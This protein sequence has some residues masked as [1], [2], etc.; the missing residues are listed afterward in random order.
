MELAWCFIPPFIL[1]YPFILPLSPLNLHTPPHYHPSVSVPVS[2]SPTIPSF[3]PPSIRSFI[4]TPIPSSI[5]LFLLHHIPH[6]SLPPLFFSLSLTLSSP[7]SLLFPLLSLTL[8][9][10]FSYQGFQ[11]RID[12]F[13]C[14]LTGGRIG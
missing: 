4:L 2:I 10:S 6:L 7:L 3:V 11:Q 1:N 5:P 14:K 13:F 8:S 9:F 12:F